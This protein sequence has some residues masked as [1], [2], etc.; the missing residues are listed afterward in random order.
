[1]TP[2]RRPPKK[3]N[4]PRPPSHTALLSKVSCQITLSWGLSRPFRSN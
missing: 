3:P 2:A 1:V 4:P